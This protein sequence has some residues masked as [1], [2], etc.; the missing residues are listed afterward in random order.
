MTTSVKIDLGERSYDIAIGSGHLQHAAAAIPGGHDG[1]AVF[2]ISDENV[3]S[4]YMAKLI[5]G[6]EGTTAGN[7][8]A[9]VLPP[10]E[11]TKAFRY[12]EQ[13]LSWLL[14]HRVDRK[15]LVIALGGGVIGDLVGFAS[16]IVLRG[17]PFMQV[18]TTLLAQIDSSIG[19]KT[20]IDMPQGK[21]LVGTFHQPVAVLVDV[22]TLQTLPRRELLAGYAEGVKHAAIADREF[23]AW[24][25]ENRDKVLSLEDVFVEQF[26]ERNCRIKAGVVQSDEREEGRRAI[27]NFGHTFGHALEAACGFD[28][29]LLHG[30]A[31]A[32]GMVLAMTLSHRMGHCPEDDVSL[33]KGHLR[34]AGLPTA[35]RDI[36]PPIAVGTS[37]LLQRMQGDKKRVSG[38]IHYV[39]SRGL[40]EAFICSDVSQDDV[41]AVLQESIDGVI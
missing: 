39:L 41:S 40:G 10:G 30:E 7:V 13:T 18:P 25:E 27:L 17:V 14:D 29:S 36:D 8:Q 12:L 28:S 11:H 5:G 34:A 19:G 38:T 3:A 21:N 26:I 35:I 23:F 6:L 32:I 4:H 2:I 24:M 15:S 37:A 9:L 22:D 16:S 20:A 1:R 31:V 33:L